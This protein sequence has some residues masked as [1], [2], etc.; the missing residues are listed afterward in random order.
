MWRLSEQ[1]SWV[2]AKISDHY[3]NKARHEFIEATTG[4]TR[5]TR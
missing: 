2:M 3:E 4:I 5:I 1:P